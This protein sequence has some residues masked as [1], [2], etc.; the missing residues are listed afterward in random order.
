MAKARY[1]LYVDEKEVMSYNHVSFLKKEAEDYF[2]SWPFWYHAKI[3]CGNKVYCS[4]FSDSKKWHKW[5][6]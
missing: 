5:Y 4:R 2:A 6:N 1:T 3:M